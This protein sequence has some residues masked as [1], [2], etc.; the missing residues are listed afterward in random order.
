MLVISVCFFFLLSPSLD[1]WKVTSYRYIITQCEPKNCLLTLCRGSTLKALKSILGPISHHPLYP[2]HWWNTTHDSVAL[3]LSFFVSL[4]DSSFSWWYIFR[5]IGNSYT[6]FYPLFEVLPTVYG[7]ICCSAL[8]VAMTYILL[9]AVHY[10]LP[11]CSLIVSC[12]NNCTH[13]WLGYCYSAL[14]G[15]DNVNIVCMSPQ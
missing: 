12:V 8:H 9:F 11:P 4:G 7:F 3:A 10:M 2:N 13:S 5:C 15:K 6:Y 1:L 14:E